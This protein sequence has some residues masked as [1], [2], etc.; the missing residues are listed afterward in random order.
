VLLGD[1][2][3]ARLEVCEDKG[4]AIGTERHLALRLGGSA[5]EI[6][7]LRRV[8]HLVVDVRERLRLSTRARGAGAVEQGVLLRT[9]E[10]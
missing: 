1:L 4:G 8:L 6:D 5:P 3:D 10:E 7:Q 9:G 2:A